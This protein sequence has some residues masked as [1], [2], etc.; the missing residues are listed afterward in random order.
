M[1]IRIEVT[2]HWR[3]AEAITPLMNLWEYYVT[4]CPDPDH[5]S[6]DRVHQNMI[7][8]NNHGHYFVGSLMIPT[9]EYCL[10]CGIEVD[11]I[12]LDWIK[13]CRWRA[14]CVVDM[15][16]SMKDQKNHEMDIA[17]ESGEDYSGRSWH[18]VDGDLHEAKQMVE[19]FTLDPEAYKGAE[20]VEL[21]EELT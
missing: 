10:A 13:E 21:P 8:G 7:E 19:A 18:Q 12:I 15:L 3:V 16:Q 4:E 20:K 9:V 14:Q 11:P 6:A 5:W 2:E 1:H 17:I